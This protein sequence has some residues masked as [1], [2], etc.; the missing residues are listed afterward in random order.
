[1]GAVTERFDSAEAAVTAFE[2]GADILLMPIDFQAARQGILDAVYSGRISE[3]RIDQSLRR[4]LMT[5]YRT[6]SGR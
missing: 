3:K 1:M 4:I 5:R 6:G 2:A